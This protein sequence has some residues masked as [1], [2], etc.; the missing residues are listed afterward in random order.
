MGIDPKLVNYYFGDLENLLDEALEQIV[1]D[2]SAV[3][4]AASETGRNSPETVRNRIAALTRFFIRNPHAWQMLAARVYESDSPWAKQLATELNTAGFG[5]LEL[6]IRLGRKANE[7]AGSFDERLLYVALIGLSEIF[8]T[9]RP[10]VEL[11][12]PDLRPDDAEER[13]IAFISDLVLHGISKP[14]PPR[15]RDK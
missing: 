10:V 15:R 6:I 5:R 7:F 14:P 8:V 4:A 3:M 1:R 13:Y 12:A 2:L 11:I 9:A